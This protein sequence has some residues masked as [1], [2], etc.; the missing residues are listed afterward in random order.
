MTSAI[1]LVH[2][3]LTRGNNEVSNFERKNGITYMYY[4]LLFMFPTIYLLRQGKPKD[5]KNSHS[6]YLQH[7]A[8]FFWNWRA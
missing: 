2:Y 5:F 7:V 3:L 4:V 1:Q 6:E 8:L